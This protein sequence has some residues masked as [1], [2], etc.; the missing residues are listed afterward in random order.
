M[1]F[2]SVVITLLFVNSTDFFIRPFTLTDNLFLII[3]LCF[4]FHLAP[5]VFPV[6]CDFNRNVSVGFACLQGLHQ[7][8][9]PSLTEM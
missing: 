1:L 8:A 2:V 7:Q 9:P 6:V 3:L 5:I 4:F